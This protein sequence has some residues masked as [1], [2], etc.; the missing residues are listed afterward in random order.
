[1]N[2]NFTLISILKKID[3]PRIERTKLH[4]LIDIV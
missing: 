3:D 1:M 4:N 2:D